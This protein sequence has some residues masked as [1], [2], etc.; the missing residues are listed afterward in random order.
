MNI[1]FYIENEIIETEKAAFAIA[2][3][4]FNGNY[5]KIQ[6]IKT[7]RDFNSFVDTYEEYRNEGCSTLDSLFLAS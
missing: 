1:F 5:A 4:C 7:K 2:D 6:R 3:E